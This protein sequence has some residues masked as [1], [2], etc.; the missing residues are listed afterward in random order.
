MKKSDF[1]KNILLIVLFIGVLSLL[2]LNC[3]SARSKNKA[4]SD[5]LMQ[6][7]ENNRLKQTIDEQGRELTYAKSL[8]IP[9]IPQ[10]Q[11]QLKESDL[12]TL[13]TK[14]I[15]KTKTEY[16]TLTIPLHDTT[17][18]FNHDTIRVERFC[19]SD[20]WLNIDGIVNEDSIKFDTLSVTNRYVIEVGEKKLGFFKGKEKTIFIRN[21]NPHT[22]T[23]EVLS[24]VIEPQKK[25]YE[26]SGWKIAGASG[27]GFLIAILL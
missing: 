12:K 8:V 9:D 1:V 25:W 13:E 14:I 5:L 6:T 2:Q 10:V 18:V 24:Y 15:F 7:D 4:I 17:I 21:E 27:L 23:K 3:D 19:F 11:E 22:K 20:E 26:R 16:D